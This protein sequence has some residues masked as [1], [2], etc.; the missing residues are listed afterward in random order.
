MTQR[1]KEGCHT[2]KQLLRPI[3]EPTIELVEIEFA[4]QQLDLDRFSRASAVK[5]N[6]ESE[7]ENQSDD[8][9]HWNKDRCFFFGW[10]LDKVSS[11]KC[12]SPSVARIA[13]T[14]N[15]IVMTGG[16]SRPSL[17]LSLRGLPRRQ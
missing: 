7:S 6:G 14:I 11:E 5:S 2:S 13:S 12:K 9:Q 3:N 17:A 16:D 1:S 4:T 15:G 10:E 8:S